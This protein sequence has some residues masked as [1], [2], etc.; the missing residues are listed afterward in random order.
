MLTD[1]TRTHAY[2]GFPEYLLLPPCLNNYEV[3]LPQKKKR[4]IGEGTEENV[5]DI[6]VDYAGVMSTGF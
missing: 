4:L 3:N 1:H 2:L 5:E 6:R